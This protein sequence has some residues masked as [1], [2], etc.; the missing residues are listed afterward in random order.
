MTW[1]N[2]GDWHIDHI[3]P[4]NSFNLE[5]EDEKTKCFHY[6]NLQPLWAID[7]MTK[8]AKYDEKTHPLKWNGEK[9]IIL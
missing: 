4:C 9:W 2:Q 7:N 1:E 5:L 3:R 6:T 8:N